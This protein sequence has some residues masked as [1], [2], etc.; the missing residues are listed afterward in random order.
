[1]GDASIPRA[2]RGSRG[3]A[4]ERCS[5][6]GVV[7]PRTPQAGAWGHP[8]AERGARARGP[9]GDVAR[10]GQPMRWPTRGIARARPFFF[11]NRG[12]NSNLDFGVRSALTRQDG[13]VVAVD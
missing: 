13:H 5:A 12:L 6:W 10:M 4:A 11:A 1:M 3:R 8:R 7:A 2:A 9:C